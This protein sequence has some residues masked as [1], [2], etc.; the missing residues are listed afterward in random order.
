MRIL[1]ATDG[2]PE[3]HAATEWLL[4]FPLPAH[5]TIR[6]ITVASLDYGRPG[7]FDSADTVRRHLRD[8]ASA[9]A[10]AAAATLA[11]R[12]ADV[13]GQVLDGDAREEIVRTAD[14][15]PADLVVVG[16]RGLTPLKRTLLG[17]VS[18]AVVRHAHCPT[19]VVRG[20][21]EGLRSIVVGI[22]G[23]PDAVT[24]A[25]FV[26]SLPLDPR[27]RVTLVGAIPPPPVPGSPELA[28]GAHFLDELLARWHVELERAMTRVE[29]S[30][31]AKV[32][33]I[34]R[35]VVPG[36]AGDEIVNTAHALGADLV[37]VGARGLGTV[38][39]LLLGSVSDYVLLHA[40]CPVLVVRRTARRSPA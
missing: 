2:S 40:D 6:V 15:W 27:A 24:A 7:T 39:R 26:G 25:G 33:T 18:T 14:T 34:E 28:A 9:T 10:R 36:H 12:W 37:V 21:S 5:S 32:G 35:R 4:T 23:S 31:N 17:S 11:K 19:L 38:G 1:L 29:G 20:R 22:D 13:E 8:A 30:F 16:A 3:A